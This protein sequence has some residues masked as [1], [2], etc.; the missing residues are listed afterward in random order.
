MGNDFLQEEL[1]KLQ[2]EYRE[3]LENASRE[4]FQKE[5]RAVIDEI[6]VFWNRHRKLVECILHHLYEPYSAYVF[7]AATI[8]DIEDYE[9]YPFVSFGRYHFWDDPLYQYLKC[10]ED[11]GA[12]VFGDK[13]RRQIHETIIDNIQ[14]I[15][16]LAEHV[17]ILPIRL[18]SNSDAK[19]IHNA[20]QQFFL[21]MFKGEFDFDYYREHIVTITDVQNAMLPDVE[22]Y[23]FFSEDDNTSNDFITRFN[24]FKES[25]D[26][27][28]HEDSSDAQIFWFSM[29]GYLSQAIDILLTCSEYRLIPYIR[30]EVAFKYLMT[31]G[32]NFKH[33]EVSDMLFKCA[34]AY[35]S[36]HVFDKNFA[37]RTE[38]T[39]YCTLLQTNNFES[40]VITEI[41]N[42]GLTLEN[43][44]MGKIESILQRNYN[45]LYGE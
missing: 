26:L 25:T 31:I 10:V 41:E 32:S 29:Y 38:F 9:H 6:N 24:H 20:A 19:L 35:I 1:V 36:H 22:K 42:E 7:T 44:A 13:M 34:I 40:S 5:S 45:L 8:L 4:I 23:V 33:G 3:I 12:T 2:I 16:S 14:I 43:L 21:S 39:E 18:L 27:P 37:K 17:Y 30:F 28:L 11:M 15:D